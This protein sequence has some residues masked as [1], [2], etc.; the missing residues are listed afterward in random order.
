MPHR[1]KK[2]QQPARINILLSSDT[3][4]E[5]TQIAEFVSTKDFGRRAS[6]AALIRLGIDMVLDLPRSELQK[7]LT[8]MEPA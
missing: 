7:R 8:N 5:L 2:W 4:E 1:H 3:K 6:K